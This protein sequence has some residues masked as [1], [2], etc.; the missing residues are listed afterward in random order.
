MRTFSQWNEA[1]LGIEATPQIWQSLITIRSNLYSSTRPLKPNALG[2]RKTPLDHL[3]YWREKMIGIKAWIHRANFPV[4]QRHLDAAISELADAMITLHQNPDPN[5]TPASYPKK[6]ADPRNAETL[7]QFSTFL[8]KQI[9]AGT[10]P[11]PILASTAEEFN[12]FIDDFKAV[13]DRLLASG[14]VSN[15]F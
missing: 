15:D 9:M 13:Y 6:G 12:A 14:E 7:Q 1:K 8:H 4:N 10:I 2:N 3:R 11:N 5:F